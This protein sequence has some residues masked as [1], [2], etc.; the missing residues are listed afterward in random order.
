MMAFVAV[1]AATA[2]DKEPATWAGLQ[3]PEVARAVTTLWSQAEK[4]IADSCGIGNLGQ[5]DQYF[6]TKLCADKPLSSLR[7]IL[8]RA[9]LCPKACMS[10][11]TA[12]ASGQGSR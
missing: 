1:Y 3:K 9:P 4:T 7:K 2:E 8:R 6:L 5:E 12:D 10:S 11:K